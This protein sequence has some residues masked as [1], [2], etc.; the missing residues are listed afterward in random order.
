PPPLPLVGNL[1][2]YARLA[3]GYEAFKQWR[4]QYGPV[5]TYWV[6]EKPVVVIANY[7]TMQE[8]FIKE[9]DTFAGRYFF[10]EGLALLRGS[11]NGIILTEG[12]E[13][14]TNRRFALQALREFGMGR[15]EMQQK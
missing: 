10:T 8:T 6:G 13:W 1:L 2:T 15:P 3:P 9:G 12:E 7:A 11:I 4:K 5:F 14:R